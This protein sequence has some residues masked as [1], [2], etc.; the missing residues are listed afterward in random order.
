VKGRSTFTAAEVAE[1]RTLIGE[2]QTAE[3]DRQK[4]LRGRM[5]RLGFYITDFADYAGFTV[6]DFDALVERGVIVVAASSAPSWQQLPAER[7][8]SHAAVEGPRR[9]ATDGELTAALRALDREPHVVAVSNWPGDLERLDLPGL[10]S[11]W[12]DTAGA[13]DLTDGLGVRVDPARIYTGLTGAT[14][15]PSGTT[16][17]STLRARVGGNH[18]RGRVRGSTFRLTLAAVLLDVLDLEIAG[19]K[20]L[21]AS[22]EAAL[23]AW[24]RDHLTVAVFPFPLAA[25]LANLEHRVLAELDPPLNLDGVPL[26]PLRTRLAQLRGRITSGNTA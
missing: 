25:A 9:T 3:R 10:Y 13:A 20:T 11:W 12:V 16:G 8:A 24:I 2:K 22:S 4:L 23:T 17:K 18:I 7:Q 19:P 6:A 5:R 15:W 1:L 21:T 26:T 14:K